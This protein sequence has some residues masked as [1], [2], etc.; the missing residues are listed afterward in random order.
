[1]LDRKKKN[2]NVRRAADYSRLQ[3]T[4]YEHGCYEYLRYLFQ[5]ANVEENLIRHIFNFPTPAFEE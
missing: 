4:Y 3:L 1:M 2:R 5:Q